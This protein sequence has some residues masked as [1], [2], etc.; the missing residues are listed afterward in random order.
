MSAVALEPPPYLLALRDR[1]EDDW[2]AH[3]AQQEAARWLL[4]DVIV[5]AATHAV[6]VIGEALRSL[7]DAFRTVWG[8]L[9]ANQKA[10]LE[11]SA[12]AESGIEEI[13]LI[14]DASCDAWVATALSRHPMGDGTGTGV[15]R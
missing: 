6:E 11:I 10:A 7:A 12:L 13:R 4:N 9:D 15:D 8:V 2:Q 14:H 3:V 1:S 5:P